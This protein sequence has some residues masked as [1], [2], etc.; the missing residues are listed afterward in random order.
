MSL[1]KSDKKIQN[2]GP[3]REREKNHKILTQT[4][5]HSSNNILQDCL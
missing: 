4:Q 2:L 3:V 1:D 5:L